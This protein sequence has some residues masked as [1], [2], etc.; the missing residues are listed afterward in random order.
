MWIVFLLLSQKS[1]W[2]LYMTPNKLLGFSLCLLEKETIPSPVFNP[3]GWFFV[4]SCT[5]QYSLKL[6]QEN[7]N[8]SRAL[9]LDNCYFFNFYP[10]NSSHINFSRLSLLPPSL[11]EASEL[12]LGFL[13]LKKFWKFSLV[14]HGLLFLIAWY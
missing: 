4:G 6:Q 12:V 5:D 1:I 7:L 2:V 13:S 10:L 3:S 14:N 8:I 11:K 9:S